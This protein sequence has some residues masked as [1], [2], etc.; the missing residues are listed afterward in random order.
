L[1]TMQTMMSPGV[2]TARPHTWKA[3]PRQ[4][5]AV[6]QTPGAVCAHHPAATANLTAR[7]SSSKLPRAE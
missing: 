1:H 4:A 5:S 2:Q 7:G 3:T 6:H